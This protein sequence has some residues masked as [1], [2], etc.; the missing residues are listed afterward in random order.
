MGGDLASTLYATLYAAPPSWSRDAL[1][2]A[3]AA[4]TTIAP[5]PSKIRRADVETAALVAAGDAHASRPVTTHDAYA[6]RGVGVVARDDTFEGRVVAERWR[7]RARALDRVCAVCRRAECPSVRRTGQPCGAIAVQPPPLPPPPVGPVTRPRIC[8]VCR[9]AE[10]P[11]VRRIDGICLAV[12]PAESVK[13][14][15]GVYVAPSAISSHGKHGSTYRAP[16]EPVAKPRVAPTRV[17][18]IAAQAEGI[19]AARETLP[20]NAPTYSAPPRGRIV[21]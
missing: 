15:Q 14:P 3:I 20:P 1:G 18:S 7:G 8:I 17:E 10:C 11:S 5:D 19:R 13:R 16:V 4:G 12:Q 21:R 2:E 9:R 6:L